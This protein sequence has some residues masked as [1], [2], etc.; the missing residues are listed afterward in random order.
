VD[1]DAAGPVA[2][3]GRR[4]VA[5]V[6]DSLVVGV[7]YVA[8]GVLFD[9]IFG[10]LVEATPDGSAIVVVAVNPVRVALELAATLVI[11]GLNFAGSWSRWGASP[12]QRVLGL[13][14]RMAAGAPR[15]AVSGDVL[16]T[17]A[18]WRRWAVL[19]VGP[20]AV[21]SLAASGALESSVLVM[22]NGA[23]YLVLLVSAARDP[24]RRGLHDRVAGTLVVRAP[25]GRA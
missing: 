14:I 22:V 19:A 9:T 25:A 17:E 6:L 11:D 20:I 3:L 23:W 1:R 5:Y 2:A 4:S 8:L 10:P 24:L 7:A 13:R 15:G 12:A 16:P 18:A 21:G